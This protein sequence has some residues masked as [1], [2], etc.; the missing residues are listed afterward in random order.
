M[1]QKRERLLHHQQFELIKK[2]EN[3]K[4]DVTPFNSLSSQTTELGLCV[5]VVQ[6][7]KGVPPFK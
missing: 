4:F 1:P 5:N 6:L 2:T 7:V 3:C